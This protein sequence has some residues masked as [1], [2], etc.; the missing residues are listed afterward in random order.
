MSAVAL[1]IDDSVEDELRA[2]GIDFIT[3]LVRQRDHANLFHD[4]QNYRQASCTALISPKTADTILSFVMRNQR[5]RETRHVMKLSL[6]H[7]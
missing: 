3:L 4:L 5:E 2:T 6:I 7:I 1:K